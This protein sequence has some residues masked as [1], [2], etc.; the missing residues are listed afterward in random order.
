MKCVVYD[1]QIPRH[2]CCY[3]SVSIR[4]KL[5]KTGQ[6]LDKAAVAAAGKKLFTL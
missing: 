2:R 4:E 3:E 5:E 6:K 1:G